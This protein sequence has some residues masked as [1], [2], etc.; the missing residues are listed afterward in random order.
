MRP[1]STDFPERH[2]RAAAEILETL[3]RLFKDG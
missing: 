2:T 3:S 1:A